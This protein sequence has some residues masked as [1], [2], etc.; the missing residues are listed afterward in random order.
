M[1]NRRCGSSLA[2]VAVLGG[3]TLLSC[4]GD[5]AVVLDGLWGGNGIELHLGERGGSASFCCASGTLASAVALDASNAFDVAG[6]YSFLFGPFIEG[7]PRTF[8][9]RYRGTVT[10]S[11]MTLSVDVASEPTI[12][13]F[14]LTQFQHGSVFCPCPLLP[15]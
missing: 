9:A 11:S 12:G 10:G 5:G 6:T 4:G 3:M 1:R 13:P 15:P 7:K 8:A 14:S 2:R